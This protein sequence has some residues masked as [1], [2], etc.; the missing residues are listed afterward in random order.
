MRRNHKGTWLPIAPLG[1]LYFKDA[2]DADPPPKDPGGAPP[3]ADPPKADP[4]KVEPPKVEPPKADPPKG[5]PPKVELSGTVLP[6]DADEDELE[7]YADKDGFIRLPFKSFRT[8]VS[9]ANK[10]VLKAIFGTD[11]KEAILKQKDEY[12]KVLTEREKERREKLA[13]S[14]RLKEDLKKATAEKDALKVEYESKEEARLA[15]E[16]AADVKKIAAGHVDEQYARFAYRDFRKHVRTLSD[17]EVDKLAADDK[18]AAWFAQWAK[19]NPKM[20]KEAAGKEDPG[21][22][23]VGANNGGKDEGKPP[24]P[25]SGS[26]DLSGKTPRPGRPNSMNKAELAEYMR[27]KGLRGSY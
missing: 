18:V 19:E 24:P 9:R 16:G 22:K 20:A 2:G 4:P 12:E 11:D 26:G 21:K 25:G 3:P 5:E 13:E 17:D 23:K 6:E 14:D 1:S 27:S 7:K 10:M 15:A 8:R